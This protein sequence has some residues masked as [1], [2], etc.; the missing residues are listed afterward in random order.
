[1]TRNQL[2][3]NKLRETQR[4]NRESE[5][6]TDLRDRAAREVARGSLIESTRHN[7]ATESLDSQKVGESQRH[8][9]A[10]EGIEKFRV[11]VESARQV[12]DKLLALQ[13]NAETKRHNIAMELK[14]SSAPQII[15]P[16][17]VQAPQPQQQPVVIDVDFRS[18]EPETAAPSLPASPSPKRLEQPKDGASH[19]S[20]RTPPPRVPR[21][22][23]RMVDMQEAQELFEDARTKGEAFTRGLLGGYILG[24]Y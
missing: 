10:S 7:K 11:G 20:T 16:V 2:E 3:Y 5:R 4:A 17:T 9:K 24:G 1:M 22:V 21:Q 19:T 14:P 23:Q 12:A 6:L 15:T 18:Y 8:N 13:K